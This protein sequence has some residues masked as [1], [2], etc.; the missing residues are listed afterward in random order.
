MTRDPATHLARARVGRQVR[1][2]PVRVRR[3][4]A[5]PSGS[6]AREAPVVVGVH[7]SVRPS[8]KPGRSTNAGCRVAAR[9]AWRYAGISCHGTVRGTHAG[10]TWARARPGVDPRPGGEVD[11]ELFESFPAHRGHQQVVAELVLGRPVPDPGVV[12]MVEA[13]RP[14]QRLPDATER[15]AVRDEV[16]HQ[17]LAEHGEAPEQVAPSVAVRSAMFHGVRSRLRRAVVVEL[18]VV[19]HDRA[20]AR[21]SRSA[22]RYSSASGISPEKPARS[23][24]Q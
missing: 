4:I 22:R 5:V 15:S 6:F 21:P 9:S 16:R 24:P 3:A 10:P 18:R 19:L 2:L 20:E 23:Q 7:Q 8:K 14:H 1:P 17:P 11:V 13:E 12:R